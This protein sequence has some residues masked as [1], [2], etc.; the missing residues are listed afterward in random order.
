MNATEFRE[1]SLISGAKN[2]DQK[3]LA[4]SNVNRT[5]F[6]RTVQYST[7][8]NI[9]TQCLL[10]KFLDNYKN[11]WG[12]VNDKNSCSKVTADFAAY[13]EQC[14]AKW[15]KMSVIISLMFT[16]MRQSSIYQT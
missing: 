15:C 12:V 2:L 5:R 10:Y 4:Q 14:K 11:K 1:I 9:K 7:M 3:L 8:L 13:I 6:I 16:N